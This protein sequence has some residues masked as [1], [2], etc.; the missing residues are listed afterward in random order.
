MIFFVFM[1]ML[2]CQ[3]VWFVLN[4]GVFIELWYSA[5]LSHVWECS[6]LTCYAV[7]YISSCS[8]DFLVTVCTSL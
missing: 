8:Y 5:V 4:Y 2:C 7:D 1:H 3:K 6:E